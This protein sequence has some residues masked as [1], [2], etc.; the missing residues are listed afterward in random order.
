MEGRQYRTSADYQAQLRQLIASYPYRLD[1]NFAKMDRIVHN[2]IEAFKEE[3]LNKEVQGVSIK[4]WSRIL[5]KG[6]EK[7]K[8]RAFEYLIRNHNRAG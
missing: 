1:T 4:E 8:K 7:E 5:Y 6:S 3:V 2:D